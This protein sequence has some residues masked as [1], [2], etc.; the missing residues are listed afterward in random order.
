MEIVAVPSSVVAVCMKETFIGMCWC[1]IAQ[2]L[3]LRRRLLFSTVYL[4]FRCRRRPSCVCLI[5]VHGLT[6]L[7]L[8]APAY[9]ILFTDNSSSLLLLLI[10]ARDRQRERSLNN[11]KAGWLNSLKNLVSNSRAVEHGFVCTISV[12]RTEE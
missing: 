8:T 10:Q 9:F 6:S 12:D 1:Y 7:L 11:H 2:S 4:P 5:L 3:L